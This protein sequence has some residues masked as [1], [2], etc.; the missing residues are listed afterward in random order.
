M[1]CLCMLLPSTRLK[2]T[3]TEHK[4][5]LFEQAKGIAQKASNRQ[6]NTVI[7]SILLKIQAKQKKGVVYTSYKELCSQVA[8]GAE[9]LHKNKPRMQNT[10]VSRDFFYLQN[11]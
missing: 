10:E 4:E 11:G 3:N 5:R 1:Q 6:P 7:Q 9:E 2:T 8:K